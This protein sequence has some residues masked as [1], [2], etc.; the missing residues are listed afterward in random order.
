MDKQQT[1]TT[2]S[3]THHFG[4]IFFP[5]HSVLSW[6]FPLMWQLLSPNLALFS[7]T[8]STGISQDLHLSLGIIQ[9]KSEKRGILR[10]FHVKFK[11]SLHVNMLY[12]TCEP[13]FQLHFG[14]FSRRYA[15]IRPLRECFWL[16]KS[17]EMILSL[18][19]FLRSLI[20]IREWIEE[21]E[22]EIINTFLSRDFDFHGKVFAN[23]ADFSVECLFLNVQ[24]SLQIVLEN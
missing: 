5:V 11:F 3:Y 13:Y 14:I 2:L 6:V 9:K 15:D 12:F 7:E 21:R 18:R 16:M 10:Y 23:S 24:M 1:N 4:V 17:V 8:L 19:E 22:E 20:F